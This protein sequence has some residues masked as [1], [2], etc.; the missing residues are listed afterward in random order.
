MGTT[1]R[2]LLPQAGAPA[3]V[4]QRARRVRPMT[5]TET[6]LLVE[7]EAGPCGTSPAGL[8]DLR[9]YTVLEADGGATACGWSRDTPAPSTCWS[10]TW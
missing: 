8:G 6:V 7:D 9:G 4:G 2:I 5:G 10:P 3:D 1:F